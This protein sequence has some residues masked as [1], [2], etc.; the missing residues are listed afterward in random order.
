MLQYDAKWFIDRWINDQEFRAAMRKDPVEALTARGVT[1]SDDD[2]AT[3]RTLDTSLPDDELI[4][5]VTKQNLN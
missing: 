5:R 4:A 3:L 2:R 1:L